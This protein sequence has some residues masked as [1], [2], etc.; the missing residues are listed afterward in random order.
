MKT[1]RFFQIGMSV[2]ANGYLK[3]FLAK[4]VYQGAGKGF[5]V[6]ILNCYACPS[7]FFSCPIGTI[8]HFMVVRAIP[9]YVLGYL[10]LIGGFVGRMPCGTLCP[11]GFF[12]ELLFK[13]SSFKIAIPRYLRSFRF[14]VLVSLVF[15]IPWIT[16][17]NWF[18]KLCPMGTLIG[19]LPWI[20][21]SHEVRSM[22]RELFWM[23]V[24]L[25]IFF[26]A[27][28]VV[29]KRPF[30]QTTCPLGAIYSLF[31]R[32]SLVRLKWDAATCTHCDK[33]FEVCP[34]E[35][36]VYE[37]ENTGHCIRC[38]D[39]TAC[40]AITVTTVLPGREPEPARVPGTAGS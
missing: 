24:A 18:S 6:P 21:M 8:Q 39:C 23:K 5:C 2:G 27:S 31:N 4:A 20:T 17:E 11:F 30:C 12:Q 32:I 36:K 13:L 35:I 16:A 9:Y 33:C 29:A 1:R 38:L 40:E 25:L 22:I 15:V 26:T 14:V 37:G 10:G 7:A 34:M 19:G 28:S 3:G